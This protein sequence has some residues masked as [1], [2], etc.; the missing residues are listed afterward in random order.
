PTPYGGCGEYEP[1]HFGRVLCA[2]RS[3]RSRSAHRI[4]DHRND[5]AGMPSPS[6]GDG[7]AH[8]LRH[9][10]FAAPD[11]AIWRTAEA[12]SV[13]G[14]ESDAALREPRSGEVKRVGVIVHAVK[15]D[16]H[17]PRFDVLFRR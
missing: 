3:D 5:C 8:V 17:G 15:A 12:A 7:G 14:V 9:Q 16:N 1:V 4:A 2:E 10:A 11:A 13:V 6:D